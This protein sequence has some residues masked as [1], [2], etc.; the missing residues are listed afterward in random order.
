M[1]KL[2]C[3]DDVLEL[4]IPEK[5]LVFEIEPQKFEMP[6]DEDAE[7]VN[8]INNPIGT[9]KL[10]DMVDSSMNVL[11]LA[12]DRTRLTPQKKI[13]P[14][15]LD[16]LNGAGVP[17]SQ[18]KV[19]IAYGTHRKMTDEE[20]FERFGKAILDRVEMLH[21]DCLDKDRLVDK[22]TTRRGT[23][24]F[25]NKDFM[26]ADFRIAIGGV[27]PHHPTGWSGGAKILLPGV[28]GQETV[29]A[30]H[31]LGATEQQLG[32][33]ETPCRQEMEDF[34]RQVGLHFIVN[35]LFDTEGN[36]FKSVAG[37]FLEA[38]RKAVEYGKQI[39][40]VKVDELADITLSSTYPCD[41]DLTQSDKGL[42]SA[43]LATEKGGEI[44]LVSRC[45]EGIAPTHGGE[46]AKLAEFDDET[47]WKMLD[48]DEVGDRFCASECMYL[49]HIKRQ[50]KATLM[51]D[52]M[53][54]NV[55]GFYYLAP[56]DLNEYLKYRLELNSD[57]KIGIIRKSGEVL[58]IPA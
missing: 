26:D 23:R 35:V 12:D 32:K 24:V 45:P 54:T 56:E 17:D 31:L 5:N 50:F 3:G 41:Y 16:E 48:A 46:M 57:L 55:M 37:D 4:D 27:V 19:I 33:I 15:I 44:I 25:V 38:H 11:I 39:F 34:A 13:I 8:S 43:E 47:L 29:C 30:M 18:I 52:P 22:G 1:V 53:L 36:I 9:P 28:A 7:I 2:H 49:N 6:A 21:H 51:M 14:L 58:P 42:F 40:G 10:R 20:V